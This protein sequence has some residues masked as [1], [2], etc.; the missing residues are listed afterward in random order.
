[1]SQEEILAQQRQ[2][3]TSLGESLTSS[4]YVNVV[5]NSTFPDPSLLA[6]LKTR[7]E[8]D[9]VSENI[10]MNETSENQAT[11]RETVEQSEFMC[12]V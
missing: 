9:N 5:S 2:L 1:M 8:R 10:E 7:R 3:M 6:F 4:V 11:P 12:K